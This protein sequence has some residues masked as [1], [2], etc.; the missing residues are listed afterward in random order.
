MRISAAVTVFVLSMAASTAFADSPILIT[1]GQG[2][3]QVT[4]GENVTDVIKVLGA[5]KTTRAAPKNSSV[6]PNGERYQWF[7]Y[8]TTT[9]NYDDSGSREGSGLFVD[10]AADGTIVKISVFYAPQYALAN[11]LHTRGRDVDNGSHERDVTRLMGAPTG[12]AESN[13]NHGLVYAGGVTFW[14]Y[15]DWMSQIDVTKPQ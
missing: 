4:L 3:G 6:I 15:H 7:N 10:A 11:G 13:G 14:F 2:I 5:P 9:G 8:V 1:P 12:T